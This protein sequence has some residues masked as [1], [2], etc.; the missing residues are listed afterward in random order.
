MFGAERLAAF[1]AVLVVLGGYLF[2]FRPL[3]AAIAA[4]YAQLDDDRI[5][6][7]RAR[8]VVD[9]EA[10]LADEQRALTAWLTSAGLDADRTTAVDRFLRAIAAHGAEDDV[11]ITTITADASAPATMPLA[12]DA[13]AFDEIPLTVTLHGTYRRILRLVN[14]LDRDGRA[15]RLTVATLGTTDRSAAHDPDLQ[16]TFHVSLLRT[17]S[18]PLGAVHVRG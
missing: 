12:A 16:A 8:A 11:R 14:D 6:L 18:A 5:S 9:H 4:Q 1:A 13:I 17:S 10:S 2:V 3:E 7:E 15:E